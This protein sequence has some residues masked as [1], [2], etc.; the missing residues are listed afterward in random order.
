MRKA[1][2]LEEEYSHNNSA[3]KWQENLNNCSGYEL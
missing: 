2:E 3:K 1:I